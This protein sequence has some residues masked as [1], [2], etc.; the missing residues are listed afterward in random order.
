MKFCNRFE[1][2]IK[3]LYNLNV[4]NL[5]FVLKNQ[6]PLDTNSFR[7]WILLY[8][9]LRQSSILKDFQASEFIF[10]LEKHKYELHIFINDENPFGKE[11]TISKKAIIFSA[12]QLLTLR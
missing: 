3:A 2:I 1:I 10:P 8:T 7:V 6:N 9:N 4:K 5:T 11:F 12:H